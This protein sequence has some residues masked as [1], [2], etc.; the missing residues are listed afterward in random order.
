MLLLC[1]E[2]LSFADGLA[3]MEALGDNAML[4]YYNVEDPLEE[5]HW[6]A[7]VVSEAFGR[8]V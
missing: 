3:E 1:V 4:R 2:D 6:I 8:K 7:G 5:S